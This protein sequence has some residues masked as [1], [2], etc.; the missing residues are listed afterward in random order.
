MTEY[1]QWGNI[2]SSGFQNEQQTGFLETT[3]DAGIPYRRQRFSD[4]GDIIQGSVTLTKDQYLQFMSWYKFKIQQGSI[5]FDYYDC[6]L[7][8][9]RTARIIDKPTY[10]SNNTYF[11]VQV[12]LYLEPATIYQDVSLVV[13]ESTTLIVDE[14][15]ELV[16]SIKLRL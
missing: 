9:T 4:I 7:G 8:E 15:S 1:W 2:K 10:S 14:A 13:D 16:A 11:D 6:R 12:K 5:A 3:P